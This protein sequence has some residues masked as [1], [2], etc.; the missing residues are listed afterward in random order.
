MGQRIAS[1]WRRAGV[2]L[3]NVF[4]LVVRDAF[5][6]WARHP[7]TLTPA[8]GSMILLLLLAGVGSL[9]GLAVRNV[10]QQEAA[11]ASV[12]NVY[13][14]DSATSQQIARLGRRLTAD[15]RVAS[16]SYV[17]KQ[18]ALRDLRT[19]PGLGPLVSDSSQNPL[20][21]SFQVGVRS[22]S[23]VGGVAGA[24]GSD[25]A[26]D[27]TYPTSYQADVYRGLQTF[28]EVGGA[29]VI[30]VLGALALVS[31]AVT[32]NAIRAGILARWDDLT[33]MRLVGAGG[34]MLRGPFVVE[35]ALTGAV[36]GLVGGAMLLG[37][38]E[39]TQQA[40]SVVLTQLLPGVGWSAAVACG[41]L[42]L[43]AGTALGSTA[44][45]AGLRGLRG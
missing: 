5:R 28:V 44:S 6:N 30:L 25:P 9:G 8:L 31:A 2:V 15:R 24:Y 23:D 33:I 20:P 17:S 3:R 37:I 34:W 16:V 19:R 42:L 22:L 11:Q 29:V 43:A 14:K 35:G 27:P 40:S 18:Q 36:A 7:R 1:L 21:A 10:L 32:A 12:L 4:E 45:L 13:L 38:F 39:V 41:G 26:V